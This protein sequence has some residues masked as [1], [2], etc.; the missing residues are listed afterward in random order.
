[1]RY[2]ASVSEA[3]DKKTRE[4]FLYNAGGQF[5]V[6]L[7]DTARFTSDVLGLAS[8]TLGVVAGVSLLL[9]VPTGGVSLAVAAPAAAWGTAIG[10]AAAGAKIVE[11]GRLLEVRPR[12]P[13]EPRSRWPL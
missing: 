3:P 6:G 9:S 7:T 13:G 2:D 12:L 4:S 11:M 10:A 5:M 1:M 8:A